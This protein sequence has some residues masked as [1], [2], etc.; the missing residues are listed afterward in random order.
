MMI[1][2]KVTCSGQ[3]GSIGYAKEI[4]DHG[5]SNGILAFVALIGPTNKGL[6]WKRKWEGLGCNRCGDQ[7]VCSLKRGLV[8]GI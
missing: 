4:M 6:D 1:M 2:F 3:L 5:K 7:L 8:N